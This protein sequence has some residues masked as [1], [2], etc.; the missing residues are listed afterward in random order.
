MFGTSFCVYVP[1]EVVFAGAIATGLCGG[2]QS[3]GA[4]SGKSTAGQYLPDA[5]QLEPGWIRPARFS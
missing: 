5:R 1:D 2:S 4:G 3:L